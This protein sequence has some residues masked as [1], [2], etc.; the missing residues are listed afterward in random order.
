MV[1][2]RHRMPAI[3]FCQI[4]HEEPGSRVAVE[5]VTPEAKSV[6]PVAELHHVARAGRRLER[7]A[8]VAGQCLRCPFV[9]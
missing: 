2:L 6:A 3:P 4:G 5:T 7:H 9:E 8:E 1:E